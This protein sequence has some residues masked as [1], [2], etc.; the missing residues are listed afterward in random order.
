M[1]I[2]DLPRPTAEKTPESQRLDLLHK[3][4]DDPACA[5]WRDQ[6]REEIR[7]LTATV[8]EA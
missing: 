5:G 8:L 7:R 2:L 6:I 1:T 4:L 3:Y